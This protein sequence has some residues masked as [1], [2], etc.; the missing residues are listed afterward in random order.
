MLNILKITDQQLHVVELEPA[1]L[2]KCEDISEVSPNTICT[3]LKDE[4]EKCQG[5]EF[6]G[7]HEMILLIKIRFYQKKFSYMTLSCETN[8]V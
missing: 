8:S 6:A 7:M 4:T 5:E 2:D 1:E 3:K